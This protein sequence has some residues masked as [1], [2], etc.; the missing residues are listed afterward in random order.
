MPSLDQARRWLSQRL[1][2]AGVEK[3]EAACEAQL[4]VEHVV[5]HDR[6]QQILHAQEQISNQQE[7]EME[8]ILRKREARVPL[9]YCLGY[10]W[11]MGMKLAVRPG[12]FIPRTDTETVVVVA[13]QL[14]LDLKLDKAVVAEIGI[15]SGAISIAMLR[16]MPGLHIVACDVSEDALTVAKENAVLQKVSDRLT[17]LAGDWRQVLPLEADAIVS[18]PPYIPAHEKDSLEPEVKDNEPSGALFGSGLDG[19]GFYRELSCEGFRHLRN[20]RGF[21][22][23]EVGDGQAQAVSG[24][25]LARDWKNPAIHNDVNGLP[26]VVS[27]IAQ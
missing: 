20:R 11:F 18:N 15:G 23:V 5:G 26:R 14:L 7:A 24:I 16:L 8:A 13:H 21:V 6:S 10:G 25:L 4:I 2:S 27:A 12:V 3:E 17:L 22:A 1:G 19:L 9:Q